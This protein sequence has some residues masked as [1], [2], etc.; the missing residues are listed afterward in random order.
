MINPFGLLYSE[1]TA[2]SLVKIDSEC[3]II[4]PGSTTWGV[5]YA[6][7]TLHSAIHDARPDIN[8]V[9]HGRILKRIKKPFLFELRK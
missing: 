7:F 8:A 2:S 1:I 3:S 9:L 5:N 6:G 4:E